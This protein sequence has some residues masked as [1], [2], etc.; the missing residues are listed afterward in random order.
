M[1]VSRVTY[2]VT[3][4]RTDEVIQSFNNYVDGRLPVAKDG[5]KS[6][7]VTRLFHS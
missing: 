2:I 3:Y 1:A 7:I 5:C 6:Q 4:H